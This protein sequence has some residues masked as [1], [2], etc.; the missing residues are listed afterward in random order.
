MSIAL[1]SIAL[2]SM[3]LSGSGFSDSL[4]AQT[5]PAAARS[6]GA[7]TSSG[8]S[9]GVPGSA[10]GQGAI[11]GLAEQ[12][13]AAQLE[14]NRIEQDHRR[15][16]AEAARRG[17]PQGATPGAA[18][19]IPGEL[20]ERDVSGAATAAAQ[21]TGNLGVQFV[22]PQGPSLA[23]NRGLMVARVD[24]R[25]P[26]AQAG[27]RPGDRIMTVHDQPVTSPEKFTGLLTR[28]PLDMPAQVVVNRNGVWQ[29]LLVNPTTLAQATARTNVAQQ[30]GIQP[31][32]VDARTMNNA[33]TAPFGGIA[34]QG[35]LG[36]GATGFARGGSGAAG[37]GAAGL[38]RNVLPNVTT[39]PSAAGNSTL[40]PSASIPPAGSTGTGP[41]GSISGTAPAAGLGAGVTLGGVNGAAAGATGAVTGA[42]SVSG[43]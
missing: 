26:L 2:V 39:T 30:A 28:S 8:G 27:L 11:R 5:Q 43:T 41:G 42:A 40:S 16:R 12:D 37:A 22:N 6:Q 36:Q 1:V 13:R 21:A 31:G 35:T 4:A 29:R 19:A 34:T 18:L 15:A 32:A 20:P 10:S 17:A 3:A 25:S 23:S 33:G 7:V 14:A 38:G 9:V 24:S